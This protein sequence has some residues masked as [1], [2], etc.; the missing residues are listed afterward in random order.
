MTRFSKTLFLTGAALLALN[1]C[2]GSKGPGEIGTQDDIVVRNKGIPGGVQEPMKAE[3]E[4]F[5]S[6]VE[7]AEA[8]P[9][10]DVSAPEPLPDNS[11]AMEA[12][13]EAHEAAQAPVTSTAADASVTTTSA[14]PS[15]NT[16]IDAVTPTEPVTTPAVT[17]PT[18]SAPVPPPASAS[19]SS[20]YPA[21]DYAQ[22]VAPAESSSQVAPT[23]APAMAES[24]YTPAPASVSGDSYPLDPNAP[25]SPKAIAKA[26]AEAGTPPVVPQMT[27]SGVN[28]NDPAIIRS[29]QAALA[30]KS[31]YVGPQTGIMDAGLLN[32]LAQYQAANGLTL[33]G[34]NEETL[35]H[36]GIIE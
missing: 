3:G 17:P 32:A 26:A 10:P 1:A 19:S 4:D 9:A 8:M 16:P 13:V 23:T 24:V 29:T 6:T 25:Y 11:P 5:T 7:Q 22:A 28:V 15:E 2:S 31:L 30:A 27:P 20:V 18:D 33:G 12:A 14:V 35:K 21:G 34:M 36:L